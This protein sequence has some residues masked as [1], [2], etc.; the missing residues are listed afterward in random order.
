M[1]GRLGSFD[2]NIFIVVLKILYACVMWYGSV[3][4]ANKR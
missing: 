2:W 4:S 3:K 1:V